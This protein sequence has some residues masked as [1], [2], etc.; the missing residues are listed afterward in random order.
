MD[1]DEFSAADVGCIDDVAV[2][3]GDAVECVV[4][5]D[6]IPDG[7]DDILVDGCV[8]AGSYRSAFGTLGRRK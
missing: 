4:C 8:C 6:E 3:D 2:V 5:D 1:D 7:S